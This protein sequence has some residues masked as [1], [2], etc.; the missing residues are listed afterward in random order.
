MIELATALRA[1]IDG[2]AQHL[3]TIGEAE[4]GRAMGEGKWVRK[5]I[6]GH[7]ID[8]AANNHQRFVRAQF[9]NPF[10]WPGYDQEAWVPVHRYRERPWAELVDLWLALNRQV[11]AVVEGVPAEKLKTSCHIG[12]AEP[13]SLE[14]WMRDYLRHLKHHLGQ[15][16]GR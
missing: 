15:L 4:A 12:D 9:A 3:K 11:A 2:A 8:S 14:W 7:L 16:G 13:A 10:V 1:E 6:L 5:E